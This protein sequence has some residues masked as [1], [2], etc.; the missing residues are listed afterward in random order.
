MDLTTYQK[1]KKPWGNT[2]LWHIRAKR[3]ISNVNLPPKDLTE[4]EDV[5]RLQ[6]RENNP[7]E[8]STQYSDTDDTESIHSDLDSFIGRKK[9]KKIWQTK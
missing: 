3:T 2:I 9:Q 6:W 8:C 1:R 5:L 7:S 4:D